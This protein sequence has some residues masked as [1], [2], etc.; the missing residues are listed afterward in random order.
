ML[1]SSTGRIVLPMGRRGEGAAG[2]GRV[3]AP[4]AWPIEYTSGYPGVK[5]GQ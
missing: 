1:A 5:V 3:G 2:T 4:S